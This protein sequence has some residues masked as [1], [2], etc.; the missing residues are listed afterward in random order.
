MRRTTL[1]LALLA[2]CAPLA[3]AQEVLSYRDLVQRLTDLKGLAVLPAPGEQCAQWS[4]YDRASVYDDVARKYVAWE[5]NGDG[6]KYIREEDGQLV[7]AEMEGPGCIWRIWSARPGGGRV[8]IYLDGAAEPAV[9]LPFK[10][11][12]DCTNEPFTRPALVHYTASGANNYVPIPYQ[13]SCKIT[14]DR[15][16]GAYYHFTYATFP[17]GTQVET[18]ARRLRPRDREAL[19]TAND[20]LS[21]CGTDPAGRRNLAKTLQVK[22]TVDPGKTTTVAEFEGPRAITAIRVKPFLP[23]PPADRAVLR[24]LALRITWDDD[25]EPA[26]WAPLGDFFGTAPGTNHYQSLP[27]GITEDGWRYSYWYMPF[28]KR[29]VVALDNDSC[30]PQTVEFEITHTPLVK[31]RT[32]VGRFHAKWHAD[33]FLPPEPER[34]IDW[35]M[36][37]TEGRGRYCGVMLHVWNPKGGWWGEGDEKFFVDG[38]KFPSTFGTGSEDY[39]GYAWCNPTLF[40]NCYHN[41]TISNNNKGHVSVNRWHI[42]DNVPFQRSFEGCIEKYCANERPTRYACVAYWYLAPD[43][44]DRYEPASVEERMNWPEPEVYRA[45]G[46]V[47]GESLEVF[48]KTGGITLAQRLDPYEGE[49][50]GNTQFWWYDNQPG[51]ILDLL[52]PVDRDGKYQITLRLTNAPDFGVVQFYFDGEKLGEPIDLYHPRVT[53]AAPK[54]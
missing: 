46:A 29:A 23:D 3:A 38:E 22:T 30:V 17:E 2:V 52:V 21:N 24:Q 19:D 49:W 37:K 39:F 48:A 12:F 9:D 47:E 25:A 26:V 34:W 51:N 7:L 8:R 18:F 40:E 36:L 42:G 32:N 4:S 31:P 13:K 6:D 45:E 16:W 43:G 54:I 53:P 14:A 27:L 10:G 20:I 33:A 41:Q 44:T 35:P 1:L 15:N 50:S 11:Y 5:A 28:E